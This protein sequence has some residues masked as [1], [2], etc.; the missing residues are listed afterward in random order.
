MRAQ[1]DADFAFSDG[2][3]MSRGPAGTDPSEI[4]AMACRSREGVLRGWT[5][6]ING[7]SPGG[8]V[9]KRLGWVEARCSRSRP[10][11]QGWKLHVSGGLSSARTVLKRCLAVLLDHD[12]A[13]KTAGSM[14][15]LRCLNYGELGL[16][17]VGKFITVYPNDDDEAVSLARR[18][19]AAT[20]GL[21]G[22][23]VPSDQRL[24]AESLVHYRY[25]SFGHDYLQL[26]LGLIVPALEG[27]DRARV[28]DIRRTAYVPL[29]W[30][31]DPFLS[32]GITVRRKQASPAVGGRYLPVATVYQSARGAVHLA[33]DV[34][35]ARS[36]VLKQAGRDAL[37]DDDGRD[38]RARLRHE[39]TVLRRLSPDSRFPDVLD[40][41]EHDGE[42]VL[43]MQDLGGETLEDVVTEYATRGCHPS[44]ETIVV[45]GREVAGALA[46]IHTRGFIYRDLKSTNVIVREDGR[47]GLVDF[48][49]AAAAG[50]SSP[51]GHGTRGYASP[52][53]RACEPPAATDDVYALGAL[54]YF[55]ATGAE[56][57]LAPRPDALLDRPVRVLNPAIPERLA[58]IIA[59]CLDP[60]PEIRFPSMEAV[61]TA[62]AEARPMFRLAPPGAVIRS[63]TPEVTRERVRTLASRIG[64]SICSA[65]E[66]AR[67]DDPPWVSSH[68][69][70]NGAPARDLNAGGAGSVLALAELVAELGVPRHRDMLAR[71]AH[72]LA[73]AED[74][75]GAPLPGLYVGE[76][77][78]AT[79]LLRAGQ[80]LEDDGLIAAAVT[81]SRRA[82]P[83]PD[84][85]PDL[86][87]G[88]AGWLR[89]Q[90]FLHSA[91]SDRAHLAAATKAGELLLRTAQ[92]GEDDSPSWTTP[93]GYGSLSGRA[94]LGYAH[95][96]AGIADCLLDLW[97]ANGDPRFRAAAAAVGRRLERSAVEVLPDRTGFDWP[98]SDGGGLAGA[99]WCRGA[100][101]IGRFLLHASLLPEFPSAR[102]LAGGAART[103]A[104]G[105]LGIG[106]TQCHGLAGSIE[107]LLDAYQA[108]GER[109]RLA[110]AR[111]LGGILEAFAIDRGA[112]V[113][114]PSESP[115]T[116]SPDYMVG[117]AGVATCLL[118]L[119]RPEDLPN[120]LTPRAFRGR[121]GRSH[122]GFRP[123]D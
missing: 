58:R 11:R 47:L 57:S 18:L 88:T 53:Q 38:A 123:T 24:R 100:G 6:V 94:A 121:R 55:V 78:I 9:D 1:P 109:E 108:W 17:Q 12:A 27:P 52:Q 73:Q 40:L 64:D 50:G 107:L 122:P 112:E 28:P 54:L 61:G 66:D 56:P 26:P 72:W 60:K 97:E 105:A 69:V 10:P 46:R 99:F 75:P 49:L 29:P 85:S 59:R 37:L 48:E 84:T 5:T 80:V 13:F 44:V 22:P 36:C 3:S 115:A 110:E 120:Q 35:G 70:A 71:G 74:L 32:A 83:T 77:G 8:S 23:R 104:H 68:E 87:N 90:L 79:A 86:F 67:G 95:G 34:V 114:F 21:R 20:R 39:A 118:R 96:A 4:V 30:V 116:F 15:T 51:L 117:Y 119:A 42:L 81:R 16:S 7:L 113:V 19:D 106:P 111:L 62:F 93:P 102:R 45:W 41:I 98:D 91:T 89:V 92:R 33:A 31:E 63:E 101:G 76:G 2:R 25:G 82:A 14:E 43:V 65:A 103:V